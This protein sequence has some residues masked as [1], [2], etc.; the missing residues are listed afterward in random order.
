MVEEKGCALLLPKGDQDPNQLSTDGIKQLFEKTN[1]DKIT[2]LEEILCRGST[3]KPEKY[4]MSVIKFAMPVDEPKINR[5]VMLYG[6]MIN[7]IGSDGRLLPEMILFCDHVRRW[8]QSSNE[9]Q[10]AVALRFVIHFPYREIMEPL[11]P[12]TRGNLDHRHSIVRSNAVIAIFK[13]YS[14][15][16]DLIPDATEII[17]NCLE[18]EVDSPIV[19]RNGLQALCV[20]DVSLALT[21]IATKF[22]SQEMPA[23]V[24]MVA[25]DL[26]GKCLLVHS[27]EYASKRSV[28]IK[29]IVRSLDCEDEPVVFEAAL[30]LT[31]VT[32]N[33]SI[34]KLAITNLIML[35]KKAS[36]LSQRIIILGHLIQIG[37]RHGGSILGELLADFMQCLADTNLEVQRK[38]FEITNHKDVLTKDNIEHYVECLKQNMEKSLDNPV[39]VALYVDN[40]AQAVNRFPGVHAKVVDFFLN[41]LCTVD[42]STSEVILQ[43][44]R[45]TSQRFPELRRGVISKLI[46]VLPEVSH[47]K[48]FR[49]ILFILGQFVQEDQIEDVLKTIMGVIGKLPLSDGNTAEGGDISKEAHSDFRKLISNPK[50]EYIKVQTASTLARLLHKLGKLN[51][52]PEIYNLHHANV[53]LAMTGLAKS[54]EGYSKK[55]VLNNIKLFLSDN[56][57][58]QRRQLFEQV[59]EMSSNSLDSIVQ[60]AHVE[61]SE[62]EDQVM[63]EAGSVM[64]YTCLKQV[65]DGHDFELDDDMSM[66]LSREDTERFK[67]IYQLSGF[68]DAI[69]AEAKVSFSGHDILLE[70]LIINR[71]DKTLQNVDL[72][73]ATRG[74]ITLV[75]K[76]GTFTL[77]PWAQHRCRASVKVESTESSFIYGNLVYEKS[78][79]ELGTTVIVL[80][81]INVDILDYIAPKDCPEDEWND[82]WKKFEWEN[83]IV[84]DTN[85]T[86]LDQFLDHITKATHMKAISNVN[87]DTSLG[88]GAF[89]AAN[90]YA[91]STFG[92]DALAN[93]SLEKTSKEGSITGHIR[94][95]SKTQ[96]IALSL[97]DTFNLVM[98]VK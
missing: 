50:K 80:H 30:L 18:K 2:A 17:Y 85:F 51:V 93:V 57:T 9:Y 61:E 41:S 56:K 39:L 77:G 25:L 20:H 90:L 58:E 69:Y 16:Q 84:V 5:L 67:G 4:L 59:L 10:R 88:S 75:E 26:L 19:M 3:E 49:G 53:I 12:A 27:D 73:I 71:C 78:G 36:H 98:K 65:E 76:P 15:F 6:E 68:G 14:R 22:S 63:K 44:I 60:R 54:L 62:E 97:G 32:Y 72:E 31:K 21:F 11:I 52:E 46:T 91:K 28:F 64:T 86:G 1:N 89:L 13:I 47:E 42:E 38:V 23:P 33:P 55:S 82:M 95:R 34:V 29:S 70:Y 66:M 96:G 8:L 7:P 45:D 92:E 43:L 24:Q 87:V 74:D 81:E 79:N 83:K 48:V 94:I 35:L 37:K 40:M